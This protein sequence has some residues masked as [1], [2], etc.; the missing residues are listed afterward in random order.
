MCLLWAFAH[1][2]PS[3][4][5]LPLTLRLYFK[6]TSSRESALIT[7]QVRQACFT[8]PKTV[9]LPFAAWVS[10]AFIHLQNTN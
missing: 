3:T 5:P 4:W 7:L 2:V 6:V 10:V 9:S 1:A 8:F